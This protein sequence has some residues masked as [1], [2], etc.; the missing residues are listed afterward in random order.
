MRAGVAGGVA[1]YRG[2]E[3][4]LVLG[5]AGQQ[6]RGARVAGGLSSLAMAATSRTATG[7]PGARS[8][9]FYAAYF[10]DPDGN[11]LNAFVMG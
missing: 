2:D 4:D 10:R 8:D 11:K 6:V 5:A 1:A 3:A 9:N 7:A